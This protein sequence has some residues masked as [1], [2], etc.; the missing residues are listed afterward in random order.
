MGSAGVPALSY[1]LTNDEKVIRIGA[2]WCLEMLR[3]NSA[4]LHPEACPPDDGDYYRR[5]CIYNQMM[6]QAAFKEYQ[7]LHERDR[8]EMQAP[9]LPS[10]FD[11]EEF[12]KKIREHARHRLSTNAPTKFE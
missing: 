6:L 11:A 3:T 9:S 8:L 12:T 1:A 5:T 4:F 7:H 2:A 10:D